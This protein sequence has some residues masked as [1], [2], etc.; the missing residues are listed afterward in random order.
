MPLADGHR[1]ESES[2]G[3]ARSRYGLGVPAGGTREPTGD[4]VFDV[5]H[6]VQQLKSDDT[7]YLAACQR[8]TCRPSL[9][10]IRPQS[11]AAVVEDTARVVCCRIQSLRTAFARLAAPQNVGGTILIGRPTLR[12]RLTDHRRSYSGPP[13]S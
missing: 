2:I 1:V 7:T 5:R 12:R 3:A 4:R 13:D 8:I 10:S 9:R 11:T 6:D